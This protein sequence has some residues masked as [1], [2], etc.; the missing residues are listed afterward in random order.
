MRD[1]IKAIPTTYSGVKFR[2]NMEANFAKWCDDWNINWMYEPEGFVLDNKCYLPDFYLKENKIIVEI[3]PLFFIKETN[4]MDI[5]FDSEEF[6]GIGLLVVEM[7]R[8]KLNIIKYSP[9]EKGDCGE[10][11]EA[12]EEMIIDMQRIWFYPDEFGCVWFCFECGALNI[13]TP[14][15]SRMSCVCC[16][17]PGRE[18]GYIYPIE[19]YQSPNKWPI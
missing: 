8:E 9:P 15:T 6:D 3:K 4:K 10:F 7:V 18:R 14:L 2:S 12:G 19:Q 13:V 11:P 17:R 5:L 1:K 16:G